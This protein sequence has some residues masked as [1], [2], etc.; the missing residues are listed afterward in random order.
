MTAMQ[1][2]LNQT[3]TAV[4]GGRRMRAEFILSLLSRKN[5]IRKMKREGDRN[6]KE[7]QSNLPA[8]GGNMPDQEWVEEQRLIEQRQRAVG[9]L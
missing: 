9:H 5:R 6:S 1:S 4:E 3:M 8:K 7:M 2:M